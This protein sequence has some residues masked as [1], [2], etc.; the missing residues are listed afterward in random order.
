MPLVHNHVAI[1][2]L[3]FHYDVE[4]ARWRWAAGLRELHGLR[5]S[6]EPSTELLLEHMHKDDRVVMIGRFQ[7]HLEHV[8]PYSC[9]YRMRDAAGR[10]RRLIFVGQSEAVDGVVRRLNG[11]VVDI[12]EPAREF[13]REAVA[14]STR[15][16]S[17]LE[18]AKGA[19]MLAFS[20]D[21]ASAFDLLQAYATRYGVTK[22]EVARAIVKR[23]ADPRREADTPSGGMTG[24]VAD[25]EDVF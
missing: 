24:I 4:T 1:P 18:Q 25:L 9:S 6:E 2:A 3:A 17:S 21:D 11:F 12:T 10:Q 8:G 15:H 16:H 7:H 5:A 14:A 13:G 19:L 22:L 20:V 23:L